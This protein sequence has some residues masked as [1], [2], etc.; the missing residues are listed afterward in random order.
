MKPFEIFRTGKHTSSKGTELSFGSGDLAAIAANYDPANYE[1]P[2][3]VGHPATN[4]PAY[5]WVKKLEVKGDRL[6]AVPGEVHDEFSEM[7]R[8]GRFK[9]R[10]VALYRP[11]QAGNPTP[12]QY[13][14]RHVGFLGAE[15][16]AVKG[17]KAV[18]FSDADADCVEFS[19]PDAWNYAWALESV[20]RLFRSVREYII[21]SSD[22]E[23]ADKV[24]PEYEIGQIAQHAADTRAEA[25]IQDRTSFSEP[26]PEE[27]DMT[28]TAEQRLAE[29]EARE[30][31]LAARE[32]QV[33]ADEA[34]FAETA[35]KAQAEAD[36]A[37]VAEQVAAGRLPVGLQASATALFSELADEELTFSE[38]DQEVK[39]TPRAAFRD[40]LSKLPVPV[41]TG[42]IATGDGPDFS[43]P[44]HVTAAI[45]TEIR[46]AEE[47]G[48]KITP[49]VA[50]M[51]LKANG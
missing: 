39:T 3:V 16:P 13:H 10:S 42:E 1:A 14:L 7:V 6:I 8:E 41:A 44:A 32:A 34:T 33:K 45:E 25:R 36:A 46:K 9:T 11:D 20:V 30:A 50:A 26:E 40:L 22:L 23:T 21:E 28:K 27:P 29:L 49:A 24:V 2:I 35:R 17:L 4:A 47:K 38:G 19:G 48:E 37:F 18:E 43:D 15:P 51:R 5:G 12:G 31:A